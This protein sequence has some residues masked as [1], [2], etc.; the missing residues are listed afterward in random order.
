[1]LLICLGHRAAAL[2]MHVLQV[3]AFLPR[4]LGLHQWKRLIFRRPGAGAH[5]THPWVRR[6]PVAREGEAWA[7]EEGEIAQ[8]AP[9]PGG[10]EAAWTR[11]DQRLASWYFLTKRPKARRSVWAARA[12]CVTFPWCTCKSPV[13]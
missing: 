10:R 1:M 12:A 9:V 3:G 11:H 2:L 4:V 8:G 6:D 13:I 5:V 7:S